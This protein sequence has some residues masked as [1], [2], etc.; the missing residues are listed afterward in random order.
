[1]S[2]PQP[3]GNLP[4]QLPAQPPGAAAG[5]AAVPPQAANAKPSRWQILLANA[6]M[7]GPTLLKIG[8]LA[9]SLLGAGIL[10]AKVT[11]APVLAATAGGTGVLVGL[12]STGALIALGMIVLIIW[13]TPS[14]DSEEDQTHNPT[15]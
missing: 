11:S 9:L 4:A 10:I 2:A 14:D 6:F 5:A 1:M 13:I 12:M 8:T 7:M 3:V 15:S